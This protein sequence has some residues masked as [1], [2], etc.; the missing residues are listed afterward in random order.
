MPIWVKIGSARASDTDCPVRKTFSR[1][2]APSSSCGTYRSKPSPSSM[3]RPSSRARS[4]AAVSAA[5]S[6][7]YASGRAVAYLR[8]TR[9]AASSPIRRVS[10]SARSSVHRRVTLA[11]S[12][13][14]GRPVGRGRLGAG[15]HRDQVLH[16]G[17]V[18][19]DDAVVAADD[20]ARPVLV[21]DGGDPAPRLGPEP[22]G[23][24]VHQHADEVPVEVDA[25]EHAD[26]AVLGAVDDEL[27]QPQQVGGGRLEQFVAGQR[28]DRGEQAASGVAVGA[29]ARAQQD[30][31]DAPPHDRDPPD[32]AVLG[33]GDQAEEDVHHLRATA[34][35]GVTTVTQSKRTARRTVDTSGD[36]KITSGA[37]LR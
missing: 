23:R 33:V 36:L 35:G 28:A 2:S 5:K 21:D 13:S 15:T 10:R 29:H 4:R 24:E 18:Q 25:A 14:T 22:V 34:G 3:G 16:A 31:G 6:S 7:L 17:Q 27:G 8:S 11:T 9:S 12:A 20:L 1:R 26:G 19:L 37:P 32:R 30:L